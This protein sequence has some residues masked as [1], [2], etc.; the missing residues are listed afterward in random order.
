[1][2]EPAVAEVGDSGGGTALHYSLAVFYML[3]ATFIIIV[4]WIIPS[5]TVSASVVFTLLG[6]ILF[7]ASIIQLVYTSELASTLCG[8]CPAPIRA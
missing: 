7:I 3:I 6:S 4:A 5:I 1:M 8:K 2:S